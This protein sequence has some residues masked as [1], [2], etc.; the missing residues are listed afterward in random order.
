MND[1]KNS[2]VNTKTFEELEIKQ[3][4]SQIEDTQLQILWL[5]EANRILDDEYTQETFCY[6]IGWIEKNAEC[7]L[8][9]Y[10]EICRKITRD[11]DGLKEQF[12]EGD[13]SREILELLYFG[14]SAFFWDNTAVEDF[15]FLY[16]EIFCHSLSDIKGEGLK[17]SLFLEYTY[18]MTG[19][20]GSN[21][22]RRKKNWKI[23][24][25]NSSDEELFR[26]FIA[27][28]S[29]EIFEYITAKMTSRREY[30]S[31]CRWFN[32]KFDSRM[33]RHLYTY[34]G[35]KLQYIINENTPDIFEQ[36]TLIFAQVYAYLQSEEEFKAEK[37]QYYLFACQREDILDESERV[38]LK[39]K[40]F[41]DVRNYLRKC[42][43]VREQMQQ[44][45]DW[46]ETE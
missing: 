3:S 45:S 35:D 2:I 22:E 12:S 1:F 17:Y 7:S 16:D 44:F 37:I 23:I 40:L 38:N 29:A 32:K 15:G 43:N 6:V 31:L 5:N 41:E 39:Q 42:E 36:R 28:I 11:I 10:K 18:F 13:R 34:L 14:D 33:Y 19:K 30:V 27:Y 4:F 24:L 8:E 46:N 20:F 26:T 9:G 21:E 25:K